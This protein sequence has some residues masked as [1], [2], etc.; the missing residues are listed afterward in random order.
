MQIKVEYGAYLEV[1][2]NYL[3][4]GTE[5]LKELE[6]EFSHPSSG[7]FFDQDDF[8]TLA[9]NFKSLERLRLMKLQ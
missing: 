9:T 7:W 5:R 3:D 2:C 4:V 8:I 6:L 1:V